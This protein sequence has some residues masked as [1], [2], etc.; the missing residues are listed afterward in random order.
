VY[1]CTHVWD[2]H[3]WSVSGAWDLDTTLM[4][5]ALGLLLLCEG[6]VHRVDTIQ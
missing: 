1:A 2:V 6:C 5:V 4:S 3:R